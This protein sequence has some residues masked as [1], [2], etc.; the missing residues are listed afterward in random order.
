MPRM[1]ARNAE[2]SIQQACGDGNSHTRGILACRTVLPSKVPRLGGLVLVA[3][4]AWSALKRNY[5]P[6]WAA[7]NE[8][9]AWVEGRLVAFT[10]G[11][12]HKK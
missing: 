1:P 2:N 11:G 5:L 6:C 4:V 9:A 10:I 8:L 7:V 12:D 3:D